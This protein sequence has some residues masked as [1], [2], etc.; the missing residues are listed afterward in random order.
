MTK[1]SLGD[2]AP[3]HAS[4]NQGL[5]QDHFRKRT[6]SAVRTRAVTSCL[7]SSHILSDVAAT[8]QR[9]HRT[10]RLLVLATLLTL[11]RPEV[12]TIKVTPSFLRKQASLPKKKIHS[13]GFA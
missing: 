1:P 4:P 8:S 12:L 3:T 2:W 13:M 5:A 9:H 10:V 11:P 7:A 6:S